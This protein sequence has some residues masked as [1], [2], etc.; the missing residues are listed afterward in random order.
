MARQ[1][2][3][4]RAPIVTAHLA[5]GAAIH[6]ELVDAASGPGGL[7]LCLAR[8]AGHGTRDLAFVPASAV[9]ALVVHD[10]DR[11]LAAPPGAPE[12]PT[13]LAL[14]RALGEARTRLQATTGAAIELHLEPSD[15]PAGQ[16]A[17]G[18]LVPSALAALTAIAEDELGRV[19]LATRLAAV[20]LGVG[21][22]ATLAL[23]DRTLTITAARRRHIRPDADALRTAIEK[24]I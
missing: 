8:A 7:H 4:V 22:Q 5:Q 6:G 24:L 9:I 1:S 2:A 14:L 18:E 19:A 11:L 21:D 15:E 12:P 17:L 10:A 23:H 20:R 3:A 13:R 16:A